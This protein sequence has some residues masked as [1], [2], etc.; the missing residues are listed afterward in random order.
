MVSE[1]EDVYRV[2]FPDLL[3]ARDIT[4]EKAKKLRLRM[5]RGCQAVKRQETKYK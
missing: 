3:V 5:N 1:K 4:K 2:M